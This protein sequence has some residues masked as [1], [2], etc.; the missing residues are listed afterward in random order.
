[1]KTV[2]VI[3]ARELSAYFDSAIAYIFA[4]VFL[5]LT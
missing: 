1:M 2:R 4:V 5:V 3:F